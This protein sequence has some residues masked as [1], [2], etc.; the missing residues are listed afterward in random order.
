[1]SNNPPSEDDFTQATV[2]DSNTLELN[3]ISRWTGSPYT[4][5]GIIMWN[6]PKDLTGYTFRM[7]IKNK[8]G[9]TV[10]AS[11]DAADSPLNII[12]F[13]VDNTLKTIT[14]TIADEDTA[15]LAFKTGVYDVEAVSP[16]E[17]SRFCYMAVFPSRKRSPPDG[18]AQFSA[19]TRHFIPGTNGRRRSPGRMYFGPSFLDFCE[20]EDRHLEDH[21]EDKVYGRTAILVGGTNHCSPTRIGSENNCLFLWMSPA[22]RACESMVEMHLRTL[23]AA[24]SLGA[25]VLQ[26]ASR[27][28]LLWSS[29][30]TEFSR[31]L[32]TLETNAGSRS[33]DA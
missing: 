29:G 15:A 19:R 14:R 23:S 10:L 6:T 5:G 13:A 21:P 30:L 1:M 22:F 27:A 7:K 25:F 20:D 8:V 12:N 33:D 11:S 17:K 31:T 3:K 16:V 2:I 24:S 18:P 4:S 26:E 32:K 9:G 28:A